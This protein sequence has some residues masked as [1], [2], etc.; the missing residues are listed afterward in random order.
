MGKVLYLYE[1][2]MP[3]VSLFREAIEDPSWR[4]YEARKIKCIKSVSPR[5]LDEYDVFVLIRPQGILPYRLAKRAR[6]KGRFVITYCDDDLYALNGRAR[7]EKYRTKYFRKTQCVGIATKR[8]K[9][10]IRTC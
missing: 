3:T 6:K 8:K 5:D 4:F 2:E 1:N 10:T 9:T 7:L